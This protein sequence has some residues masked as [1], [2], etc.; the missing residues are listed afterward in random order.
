MPEPV[1]PLPVLPVRVRAAIAAAP[2]YVAGR[3]PSTGG[4]PVAR[5][6]SNESS[7]PPLASVLEALSRS[8]SHLHRYPDS[9]GAPLREA[10]AQFTSLRPEDVVAGPGSVALCRLLLETVAGHGDEVIFA[11]RSFEAYPQLTGLAGA[12]AVPVPLTGS[13]GHDLPAM[14]AAVT[15]ATRLVFICSPNNP[16]GPIVSAKDMTG[17]MHS[18]PADLLVVFDEAYGEYVD[19]AAGAPDPLALLG[20]HPNVVV[21]RTFSKAYGLAGARLGYALAQ[22]ELAS[23]L[24]AAQVPFAVS[25]P[26]AAAGI[27]GLSAAAQGELRE[28]VAAVASRRGQTRE[29]LRS[30]DVD[31]P[32]A[33]GNFVWLPLGERS[34]SIAASLEE[35]GVF[36]R[37]FAGEGIRITIGD[38]N[39]MAL[40]REALPLLLSRAVDRAG[41]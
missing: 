22:P 4:R 14:A 5:L 32:A 27:A 9:T 16:T 26:A 41:A 29:W 21:L 12:T 24:R 31:V 35:Q 19:P 17:F 7:Q 37:P 15:E 39:E 20:A 2:R 8:G 34:S 6:A 40:L 13:A 28:R 30:L 10:I 18:V 11:W 38:E 25:G 1:P 36:T 33:Q 23:L 3:R